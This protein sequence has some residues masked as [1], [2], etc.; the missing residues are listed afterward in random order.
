M[1][2]N[3]HGCSWSVFSHINLEDIMADFMITSNKND[4]KNMI[5]RKVIDNFWD[6]E[7]GPKLTYRKS[8]D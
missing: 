7:F 2:C 3:K 4:S 1:I 8:T 5:S 6:W